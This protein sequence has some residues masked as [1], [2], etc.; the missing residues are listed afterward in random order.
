MW[1]GLFGR[2]S[3]LEPVERL[4]AG[5]QTVRR[6]RHTLTRQHRQRS[7]ANFAEA[8][9]NQNPIPGP[10]MCLSAPSAVTD[11]RQLSASRT[12]AREPLAFHLA[13]L[14]LFAGTWDKNDHGREGSPRNRT[15]AKAHDS[16]ALPSLLNIRIHAEKESYPYPPADWPLT[17]HGPLHFLTPTPSTTYPSHYPAT[18]TPQWYNEAKRTSRS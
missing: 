2:P 17:V 18:A 3:L 15:L 16:A 1:C 12:P 8:A 6:T 9:T 5:Q 10:V 4:L 11:D 13:G 14:A 7:A